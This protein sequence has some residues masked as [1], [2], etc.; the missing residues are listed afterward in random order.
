MRSLK[1]AQGGSRRRNGSFGSAADVDARQLYV[2]FG[3]EAE[4]QTGS[5]HLMFA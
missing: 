5:D 4:V 3:P 2:C 1:V